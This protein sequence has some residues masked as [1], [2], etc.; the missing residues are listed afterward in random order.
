MYKK[1]YEYLNNLLNELEKMSKENFKTKVLKLNGVMNK[2]L[3]N[4]VIDEVL[5]KKEIDD[6]DLSYNSKDYNITLDEF[7][8]VF[9]YLEEKYRKY[10]IDITKDFSEYIFYFKYKE[11]IFCWRL[12]IGQGS[13]CQI[14]IS[15]NNLLKKVIIIKNI[16]RRI[17]FYK[18]I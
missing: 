18:D 2:K 12:V 1:T 14:Y 11:N 16:D 7:K 15:E 5:R 4:K 10:I 3:F 6:E 8:D 17:K 9:F 13:F